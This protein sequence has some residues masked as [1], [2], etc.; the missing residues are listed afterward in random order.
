MKKRLRMAHLKNK[1][2]NVGSFFFHRNGHLCEFCKFQLYKFDKFNWTA[3]QVE[4]LAAKKLILTKATKFKWRFPWG[5][6]RQI[7]PEHFSSE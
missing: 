1:V 5:Y 2:V 7:L 6:C 3:S 4:A